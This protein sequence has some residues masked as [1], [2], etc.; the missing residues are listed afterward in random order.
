MNA[1]KST[2]TN[3]VVQNIILR[4]QQLDITLKGEAI[5]I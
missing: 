4:K 1:A 5:Y 3:M 2:I